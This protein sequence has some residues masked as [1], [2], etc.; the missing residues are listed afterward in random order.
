[1]R[2]R[3]RC[4]SQV[5]TSV[6]RPAPDRAR[7]P[8]CERSTGPGPWHDRGVIPADPRWVLHVDLDQFLAAVEVLRRPE[9]AGLP[10][11]VGGRGTRTERAVVSTASYEAR[12][13]G[14]RSGMPLRTAHKKCPDA[15]FLP[16]DFPV[17]EAASAEVMARCGRWSGAVC[18][19]SSRCSAGTRRSWA[20][21]P[22][23]AT[24]ATRIEFAGQVREA[25]L[26]ATRLH[27]S[28]GVGNNKLQAKIATDFGKPRGVYTI[29]DETWFDEMGARPARAL[30]G[31]GAKIAG[32]LDSPRDR[33]RARARCVG[34]RGAGG[35]VRADHGAVVPPARPRRRQQPGR[36][37]AVGAAGPRARGDLPARPR[38]GRVRRRGPRADGRVAREHRRRGPAGDAGAPEG[39]LPDFFTAHPLAGRCRSRAATCG[40]SATPRWRCWTE[41]RAGQAGAAARRPAG[42]GAS[43]K[44]ATDRLARP[45]DA[46][47]SST[48]ESTTATRSPPVRLRRPRAAAGTTHRGSGCPRRS[49]AR[50]RSRAARRPARAGRAG[51]R[52]RR[53]PAARGRRR[54]G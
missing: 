45:S 33:H 20:P 9:L 43:P 18:R 34:H 10:V 12:E 48:T 39:S 2:A 54:R 52:G 22:A 49:A 31:I 44:A 4:R 35:G 6:S 25:V 46:C 24:W 36:R 32:R 27:C 16:V 30:W 17:Y 3:V 7:S 28:V 38:V 37:D 47:S 8:T 1:M 41:G 13:F 14:V 40:C 5:R 23:T 26:A 50:Q 29:T 21:V 19:S 42:D 51:R 11:V 15:V 53:S